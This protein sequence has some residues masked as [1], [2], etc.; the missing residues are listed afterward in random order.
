MNN[1]IQVFYDFI[2]K[3]S[4]SIL[5]FLYTLI[6]YLNF[7]FIKNKTIKTMYD[8]VIKIKEK[9]NAALSLELKDLQIKSHNINSKINKLQSEIRGLESKIKFLEKNLTS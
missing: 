9:E 6:S 8:S 4:K 5:E 2:I 3:L 7:T 1:L